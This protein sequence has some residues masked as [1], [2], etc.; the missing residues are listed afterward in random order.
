MGVSHGC[1]RVSP[2]SRNHTHSIYPVL[3][4]SAVHVNCVGQVMVS[5]P[6]AAAAVS[7]E[8]NV[9]NISGISAH[10]KDGNIYNSM[11]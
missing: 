8:E 10:S 11:E 7:Q 5:L 6:I 4:M 1:L 3:Y 9:W 2:N